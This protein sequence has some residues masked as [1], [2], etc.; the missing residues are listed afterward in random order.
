MPEKRGNYMT[1]SMFVDVGHGE[2]KVYWRS[3]RGI[4]IF[5]N[6][7]SIYWYSKKQPPVETSTFGA[8]LCAI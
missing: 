3:E 8:E 2:N 4:L 7:S 1:V 6:K 5:M